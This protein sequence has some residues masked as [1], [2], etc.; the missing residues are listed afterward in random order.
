[1]T[2][3]IMTDNKQI[4]LSDL[5]V[6][7]DGVLRNTTRR[8]PSPEKIA[9]GLWLRQSREAF[10]YTRSRFARLLGY[11]GTRKA[12]RKRLYLRETG[13]LG[14]AQEN[15]EKIQFWMKNGLPDDAPLPNLNVSREAFWK[16]HKASFPRVLELNSNRH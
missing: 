15:V 10:G 13:R 12:L 4:P 5:K 14:M 3:Q 16:Q 1:L 7:S 9:F 8:N 2:V 6:L 11:Q